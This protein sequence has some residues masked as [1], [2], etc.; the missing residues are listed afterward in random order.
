MPAWE[1]AL[2]E[3]K[4]TYM[5][6]HNMYEMSLADEKQYWDDLLNLTDLSEKERGQIQ[7]KSASLRLRMLKEDAD[8]SRNLTLEQIEEMKR[9]SNDVVDLAQEEA[10]QKY[11][12]GEINNEQRLEAERSFEQQRY[13]INRKALEDRLELLSKDPNMNPVEY[14]KLKNRILEIERKHVLDKQKIDNKIEVEQAAP[15]LN[16][17]KSME[18][19]FSSAITNMLTKA[20][21][22]RQAMGSIFKSIL[23]TFT[24]EMIAKPLAQTAMRLIRETALY[25]SFFGIKK[26]LFAGDVAAQISA[27]TAG[28]ASTAAKG[29]TEIPVVAGT[30]AAKSADSVASIPYVGP[31][32]AAAAFAATMAMVMGALSGGGGGSS[33]S[34]SSSVPSAE[35]GWDIPSGATGLMRYHEKE[36]MLPQQHAD[37]IR[38]LGE[39]GGMSGV[40][41]QPI[42]I[43]AL[44]ARNVRDFLKANSHAMAPAL[45]NL[46]RN[47]TSGKS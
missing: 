42:V 17:F 16:I 1:A 24:E 29:A 45:R 40:S 44:D 37:T 15:K 23:S 12:L 33:S 14:Q 47:F 28:A 30:A 32:L 3:R 7:R 35:G 13:E 9:A 46:A 34:S 6:E 2:S 39:N 21:T 4:A 27:D 25:Q 26:G 10:D 31:V 22:F 20:Q 5:E 43:Q 11:A 41:S 36:M 8:N 18:T 19:S 38:R